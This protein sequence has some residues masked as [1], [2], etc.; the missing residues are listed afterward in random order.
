MKSMAAAEVSSSIVSIRFLVSA[1]VSSMVC[2]PT[3][4]KRGSTVGSSRSVALHLSTPRGPKRSLKRGVLRIVGVLRLFLGV[5]V[6]EIAEELVEAVHRRQ[7]L[8]VVAEMVLAELA[9][10]V[11]ERLQRLGDGH[12]LGL[13]AE[14]G[15]GQ[16]DLGKAGAQRRLAGDERRAARRAALL[17]VIVGEHHA[18]AGDAV[19]VRRAIAH[20]AERIGADVGLSDVVAHDDEDVRPADR[21][22]PAA[23]GA[24]C[25]C[26]SA[27]EVSVAAATSADEAEQHVAAA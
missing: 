13:Q 26:A 1:P 6:I 20:H 18:F 19:D 14:V 23:A 5:E 25:A 4:P 17:G 11:A 15:A 12:V 2:L 10:G 24:F 3:L 22:A 7:E 16:A 27:P 9:G 8:V 21:M